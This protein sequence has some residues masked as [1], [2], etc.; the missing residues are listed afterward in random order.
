[1]GCQSCASKIKSSFKNATNSIKTLAKAA[2]TQDN[3]VKWFK[4]GVT[5]I[6]KC[7]G[8]ISLYTD[9][10][11]GKNRQICRTCEFS[12][13]VDGKLVANSQCEAKDP[14]TGE[15]CGCF[16]LCK[17]Q[18]GPPC[19]LNKWTHLTINGNDTGV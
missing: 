6:L 1:M 14:K 15:I 12:T 10:E 7:I 16:I 3:K 5:G 17:T 11:I 4:D 18:S 8:N 13:K 19:P 9:E 2:S